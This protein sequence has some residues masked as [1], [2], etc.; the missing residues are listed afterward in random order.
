MAGRKSVKV[1]FPGEE[2]CEGEKRIVNRRQDTTTGR[3]VEKWS[4]SRVLLPVLWKSG[5]IVWEPKLLD[6]R[7]PHR[8]AIGAV[9]GEPRTSTIA[10]LQGYD[11]AI[12]VDETRPTPQQHL[13]PKRSREDETS[14]GALQDPG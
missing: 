9:G 8:S 14:T 6:L 1:S 5:N 11:T 10:L 7:P 13:H 2:L 4:P 3:R 12:G